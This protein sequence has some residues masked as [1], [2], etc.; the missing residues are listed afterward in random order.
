MIKIDKGMPIPAHI[1]RPGAPSVLP[2]RDMDAGDSFFSPDHYVSHTAGKEAGKKL[3]NTAGWRKA[4]P[5]S[6]W[7]IRTVIENGVRGVRVWRVK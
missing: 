2:W 3:M 5:G 4:I 7:S 1:E 6:K